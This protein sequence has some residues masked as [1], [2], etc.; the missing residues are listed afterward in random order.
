MEVQSVGTTVLQSCHWKCRRRFSP[1]CTPRAWSRAAGA[2][3]ARGETWSTVESSSAGRSSLLSCATCTAIR[4]AR[5]TTK[6]NIS[7]TILSGIYSKISTSSG[8]N[9]H[10]GEIVRFILPIQWLT[11]SVFSARFYLQK[12]QFN[13]FYFRFSGALENS[14]RVHQ[15]E[16]PSWHKCCHSSIHSAAARNEIDE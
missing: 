9:M 12:K 3:A 6:S 11:V 2:F 7:R 4:T 1:T 15:G 13:K 16:A 14:G 10:L 8:G 5:S